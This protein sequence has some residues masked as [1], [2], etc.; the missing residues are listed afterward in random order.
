MSILNFCN[1]LFAEKFGRQRA[2]EYTDVTNKEK[3]LNGFDPVIYYPT[4]WRA[5]NVE[6][7]RGKFPAFQMYGATVP[8]NPEYYQKNYV[9]I[10]PIKQ[11]P[12][13]DEQK[14]YETVRKS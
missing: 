1:S 10:F 11:Q 5:N 2:C 13:I 14:P 9:G 7:L 12:T 3:Q 4:N 8:V 6:P